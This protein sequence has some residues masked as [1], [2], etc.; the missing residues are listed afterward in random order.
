MNKFLGKVVKENHKNSSAIIF[1]MSTLNGSQQKMKTPTT[2][3][4][5]LIICMRKGEIEIKIEK[6]SFSRIID[7]CLLFW[8]LFR[9]RRSCASASDHQS[10]NYSRRR[11]RSLIWMW[12]Y[13]LFLLLPSFI[14]ARRRNE[15]NF[16]DVTSSFCQSNHDRVRSRRR[17][18][19]FPLK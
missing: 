18:E 4:I 2:A 12:V 9:D 13:E 14:I 17:N 7:I 11:R 8:W 15:W 1:T 5:I 6:F 3:S 19:K 10:E 16:V